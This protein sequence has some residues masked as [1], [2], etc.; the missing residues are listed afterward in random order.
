M[1]TRWLY[2]ALAVLALA[3]VCS[4]VP[5]QSVMCKNNNDCDFNGACTMCQNSF[6][7]QGRPCGG[8][9]VVDTDC[10][11]QGACIHCKEGQCSDRAPIPPSPAPAPSYNA[12][13]TC[14]LNG[15]KQYCGPVQFVTVEHNWKEETCWMLST[16]L[17]YAGYF[18][19]G[20]TDN[21]SVVWENS[22]YPSPDCGWQSGS[23]NARFNTTKQCI[24]AW[25][26]S[27]CN[28][29][30]PIGVGPDWTANDC[31][32]FAS[33]VFGS[34][35]VDYRLMCTYDYFQ[36]GY[37]IGGANGALPPSDCGWTNNTKKAAGGGV[38]AK[39]AADVHTH[40]QR[41]GEEAAATAQAEAVKL[42]LAWNTAQNSV[43]AVNVNELWSFEGC[44]QW[45]HEYM[46]SSVMQVGCIFRDTFSLGAKGG[47]VPDRNC[48]W[49]L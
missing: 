21:T 1:S 39:T 13:K 26:D 43:L 22:D 9:C 29:L 46:S 23:G 34:F 48:G 42:C 35:M 8:L 32:D 30:T 12:T 36:G 19:L 3:G 10:D 47:G 31:K 14:V 18:D 7:N 41:E 15:E 49:V 11:Q 38:Q 20:C 5:C 6:C 45:G 4:S 25:A 17:G 16:D 24:A 2:V 37:S 28:V 44:Y 27:G 40:A 33:A